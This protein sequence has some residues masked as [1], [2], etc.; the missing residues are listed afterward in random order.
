MYYEADLT[1]PNLT[2]I[3]PDADLIAWHAS[4]DICAYRKGGKEIFAMDGD[5]L[6]LDSHHWPSAFQLVLE[7]CNLDRVEFEDYTAWLKS[8]LFN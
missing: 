6:V 4:K 8:K 1:P 5:A 2:H 7:L 3:P